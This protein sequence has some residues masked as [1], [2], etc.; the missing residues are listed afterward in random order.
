MIKLQAKLRTNDIQIKK[1]ETNKTNA[2][3]HIATILFLVKQVMDNTPEFNKEEFLEI[4]KISM[5]DYLLG[6]ESE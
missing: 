1:Y 5:D 4:I 2:M 3:E 6:E